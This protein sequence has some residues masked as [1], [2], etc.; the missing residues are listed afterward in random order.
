MLTGTLNG[1][2]ISSGKVTAD[3]ISFTAGSTTY[4][5][6]VNGGGTAI[7]GGNLTATKAN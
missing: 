7:A 1:T 2:A 6:K 3:Q 4:T 5:G